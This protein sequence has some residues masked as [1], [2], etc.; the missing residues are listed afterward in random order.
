MTAD[1]TS[2]LKCVSLAAQKLRRLFIVIPDDT[3]SQKKTRKQPY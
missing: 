3:R 1:Q 2:A